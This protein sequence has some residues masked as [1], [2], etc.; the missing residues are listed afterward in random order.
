VTRFARAGQLARWTGLYALL[1]SGLFYFTYKFYQPAGGGTDYYLYYPMYRW[2][3]NLHA[4]HA[5]YIYRQVSA[6][7]THLIYEYG[8]YYHT[9]IAFVQAGYDQRI[10]FA[11]LLTNDLALLAC[12]TITA[13]TTQRLSPGLPRSAVLFAG[14]FCYLEFFAQQCGMGPITDGVAW[15]LMAIGFLGYVSGS[16]ITVAVAMTVCI[17]ERESIPLM[18]GAFAGVRLVLS[19]DHRRFDAAVIALS[20]AAFAAYFA[21]RTAWLPVA[22]HP[23]QTHAAGYLRGLSRWR[24]SMTAN[25]LFQD[26]LTQ[27]LLILLGLTLGWRRLSRAPPLARPIRQLIVALFVTAGVMVVVCIAAE[28]TIGRIVTMLTPVAAPLLALALFAEEAPPAPA[29]ARTQAAAVA[30]SRAT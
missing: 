30:A 5:P 22:G 21:M 29:D 19:P 24:R 27:N 23:L 28:T 20:A 7:L 11:A 12:A 13:I 14:A 8:P 1:S 18:L 4:A 26:F 3:L 17:V 6:V 25:V 2:P 15:L 9:A 10:F 16:L